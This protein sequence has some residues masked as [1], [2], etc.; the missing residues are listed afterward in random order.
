[1][2]WEREF[3][4]I[5]LDES[6]HVIG[7]IERSVPTLTG[8]PSRYLIHIK[9]GE[10]PFEYQAGNGIGP[11]GKVQ[12]NSIR[13]HLGGDLIVQPDGTLK[14]SE[15]TTFDPRDFEKQMIAKLNAHH[16][17][18]RAYGKKHGAPELRLKK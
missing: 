16:A 3:H 1:M 11:D 17:A 13:I 10:G 6:E 12:H 8:D 4:H 9:M 7:L 2:S 14:D 5:N 15:G 18:L